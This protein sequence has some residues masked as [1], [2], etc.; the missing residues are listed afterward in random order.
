M[1]AEPSHHL[2][3][4]LTGALIYFMVVFAPWAFGTTEEWSMRV[5]NTAGFALGISLL[6]KILLRKMS[7]YK[8]PRWASG[9]RS[10]RLLVV[11]LAVLTGALL[12]WCG[13][14]AWN[15]SAVYSAVELQFEYR[16]YIPW[17]PHS[18]DARH[19]WPL[20]WNYSA[21]ACFFWAARDWILTGTARDEE[22]GSRRSRTIPVRL[23][24]LIWVLTVNGALV[25]IEGIIQRLEGSGKLLFLVQPEVNKGAESQFGP[26]AYRSNAAQFFNLVWPVG[27]G[28]WY[29]LHR[30]RNPARPPLHHL[31]LSCV[32]IMAACPLVSDSRGGAIVT[33]G[34]LA[35]GGLVL[36]LAMQNEHWAMRSAPLV[37]GLATLALGLNLGW[38]TL[39][40]RM[41]T[42]ENDLGLREEMFTTARKIAADYPWYGTGPG[43]FDPVFQLYRSS[44]DEYWPGQLHN[45]WLETRITFGG[46]GLAMCLGAL[47]LA[48]VR[49]FFSGGIP[50]NWGFPA[51]LWLSIGGCLFH[52]RFDFPLQIYSVLFVFLLNCMLLTVLSRRT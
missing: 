2:C 19:S 34:S 20:F 21:L 18:F 9:S 12:I 40:K 8:R 3:D 4:W 43:T 11:G 50:V 48:L 31:L 28:F 46:I 37:F 45:D 36:F 35:I 30:R 13:V 16:E 51:F 5:M 6:V 49:W 17:L 42:I 14:S 25:G 29:L 33:A 44:P 38:D 23:Q 10:A 52:A 47:V 27:L 32:M 15:A 39:T 7:E 41:Q 1:K 26:Y 22:E 24:R